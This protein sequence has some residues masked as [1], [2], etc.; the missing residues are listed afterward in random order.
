M[1]LTTTQCNL[2]STQCY[3]SW[4][5]LCDQAKIYNLISPRPL[6]KANLNKNMSALP[7]IA[8]TFTAV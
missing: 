3:G 1:E 2:K 7:E 5:C 8:D 6:K 4:S